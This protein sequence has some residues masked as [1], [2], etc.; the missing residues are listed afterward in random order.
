MKNLK[1]FTYF[2]SF[3]NLNQWLLELADQIYL[4]DWKTDSKTITVLY[5]V[6]S[7]NKT[8]NEILKIFDH[9]DTL[10]AELRKA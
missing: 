6:Y 4:E 8:D 9:A 10:A 1:Q 7:E 5:G 3:N 2:I